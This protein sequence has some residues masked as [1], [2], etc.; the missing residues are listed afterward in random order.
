M[1]MQGQKGSMRFQHQSE[2]MVPETLG[3]GAVNRYRFAAS[4]QRR[5]PFFDFNRHVA[6]DNQP[7]DRVDSKLGEDLLT[8][9]RLVDQAEIRIFRFVVGAL[10]PN[11]TPLWVRNAS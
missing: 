11:K 7:M 4:F 2:S 3:K 9:P 8:K 1:I 5:L 6:V 10:V